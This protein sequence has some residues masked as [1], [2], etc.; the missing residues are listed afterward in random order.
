MDF[1]KAAESMQLPLDD[2]LSLVQK[3]L[4]RLPQY[5]EG[6]FSAKNSGD[7]KRLAAEAHKL[8]GV[9]LNLRFEE[10]AECAKKIEI[11]AKGEAQIADD[12]FGMLEHLI[13]EIKQ[14][15]LAKENRDG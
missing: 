3:F 5:R 7:M 15:M 10:L 8:K 12:V 4:E 1:K 11:I 13:M 14:L 6:I 9:A 2:Y